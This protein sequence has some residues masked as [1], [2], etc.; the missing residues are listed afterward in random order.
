MLLFQEISLP[1]SYTKVFLRAFRR[2][3]L[4]FITRSIKHDMVYIL[5][6]GENIFIL[7]FYFH[8]KGLY[9]LKASNHFGRNFNLRDYHEYVIRLPAHQIRVSSPYF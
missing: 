2:H 5:F 1:D 7:T 9:T 8:F 4:I 6:F 3:L